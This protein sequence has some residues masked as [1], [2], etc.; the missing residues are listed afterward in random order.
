M[1]TPLEKL[2]ELDACEPAIEW[3]K[4]KTWE[5][6][7][8]QCERGDW[9]LWLFQKMN[10]GDLQLITL[11]KARCANTVRH[12]MGDERSRNA[13]DVAERFGLGNATLEEL[14]EVSYTAFASAF[15][16]SPSSYAAYAASVAFAAS[17]AAYA[18]DDRK[19]NQLLTAN[20]VRGTISFDK[21]NL[22]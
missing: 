14:K 16:A 22:S 1:G 5:E 21:F 11:A 7:Y 10:P 13:V 20:I 4:N 12:L 19:E 15:S 2:I 9:L 17:Y 8:R 18:S 6:I 3:A